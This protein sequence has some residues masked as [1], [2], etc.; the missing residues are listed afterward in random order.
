MDLAGWFQALAKFQ[1]AGMPIHNHRDGRAQPIFVTKPFLDAGVEIIQMLDNLQNRITCH[2][3][4]TFP[5][6]DVS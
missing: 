5:S 2:G 3:K 1:G 4:G 6:R